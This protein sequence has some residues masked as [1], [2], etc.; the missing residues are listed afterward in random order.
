MHMH[1]P[2]CAHYAVGKATSKHAY[3]ICI[4]DYC[5]LDLWP[6][7]LRKG[8]SVNAE[9][10]CHFWLCFYA[11]LFELKARIDRK[12]SGQNLIKSHPMEISIRTGRCLGCSIIRPVSQWQL[13]AAGCSSQL[14]LLLLLLLLSWF[15]LLLLAL[16]LLRVLRKQFTNIR[17]Q[18][19]A[20][21]I[22]IHLSQHTIVSVSSVIS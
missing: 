21:L 11:S 15:L 10:S 4:R 1:P 19:L 13:W 7:Q 22:F 16:T 8:I 17:L 18:L 6:L 12:M 20:R 3:E 2:R 9:C 14:L 5:D